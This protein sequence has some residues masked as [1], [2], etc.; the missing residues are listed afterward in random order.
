MNTNVDFK[1][2]LQD[3]TLPNGEIVKDKK[4]VVRLDNSKVLGIVSPQ[5]EIVPHVKVLE[6]FDSLDFLKRTKVDVCKEG[7][8]LF[9]EYRLQNGIKHEFE[10]QKGDVVDFGIRAFN[11]YNQQTGIGFEL[12]AYRLVCTNGLVVPKGLSRLS[13]RHFNNDRINDFGG[14]VRQQFGN[15]EETVQIWKKWLDTK[16]SKERISDFYDS[17]R[18]GKKEKER[19]VVESVKDNESLGVWGVFNVATRYVS[20]ELKIMNKSNRMIAVKNKE[21]ELLSKFYL[22]NWN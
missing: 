19:L 21:R 22:F 10:V 1:V 2:E 7:A 11:S 5:Y 20:H 15:V 9:A 12:I 3:L 18:I 16:P 13:F 14:V 4:A 8:L 17:V 6:T